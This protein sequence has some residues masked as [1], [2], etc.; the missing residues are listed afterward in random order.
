M[1]KAIAELRYYLTKPQKKK[2]SIFEY[3]YI[4]YNH[5]Y[6][7]APAAIEQL[8]PA[9]RDMGLTLV[10]D[11]INNLE[12]LQA[13]MQKRAVSEDIGID[14]ILMMPDILTHSSEG[15]REIIKFANEHK[16][17]IAGTMAYT[18]DHGAVFSYCPDAFEMG[19]L[20]AF[21]ADKIFKG[22]PAGTI[23]LVS[24]EAHLR[25]NYKVAQEL[26]LNVDEGLL[27]QADEI[28]R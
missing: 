15:F 9:I 12:E 13:A 8:R 3:F 18:A 21:Q 20:A 14:A 26:G 27:S 23:P 10:E 4:I 22:T 11:L 7:N 19:I 5:N 2:I 28:I 24:P 25:I 17:P 1:S 16:V 6:P